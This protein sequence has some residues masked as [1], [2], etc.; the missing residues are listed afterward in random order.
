MQYLS[1]V[2][3]FLTHT[4]YAFAGGLPSPYAQGSSE[5]VQNFAPSAPQQPEVKSLETKK[6]TQLSESGSHSEILSKEQTEFI[7]DFVTTYLHPYITG[8]ITKETEDKNR[9]PMQEQLFDAM[10]ELTE[11]QKQKAEK[12]AYANYVIRAA[13]GLYVHEKRHSNSPTIKVE[14]NSFDVLIA[15]LEKALPRDFPDREISP[16]TLRIQAAKALNDVTQLRQKINYHCRSA[17]FLRSPGNP[18]DR[19]AKLKALEASGKL[20][21]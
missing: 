6:V 20:F 12:L 8:Q 17:A 5:K 10:G 13:Q 19:H 16:K 3:Q 1:V 2:P 15:A 4:F 9:K 21:F 18:K 7:S 11:E 14:S